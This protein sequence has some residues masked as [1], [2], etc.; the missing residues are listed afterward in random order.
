MLQ[1]LSSS[2]N[3]VLR[4]KF[5]KQ[6]EDLRSKVMTSADPKKIKAGLVSGYML[7]ELV[8]SWVT[9][10][11]DGK[12]PSI[13]DTWTNVCQAELR[14]QVA[15]LQTKY[16]T[17][18]AQIVDSL[19]LAEN[20]LLSWYRGVLEDARKV[21]QAHTS[22]LQESLRA[23]A[24]DDLEQ[25]F[26]D[27]FSALQHLNKTRA[28][29]KLVE[30]LDKYVAPVEQVVERR[31]YECWGGERGF[32]EAKERAKRGVLAAHGSN[33][34]CAASAPAVLI[35][36]LEKLT[37]KAAQGMLQHLQVTHPIQQLELSLQHLQFF[38][39][40]AFTPVSIQNLLPRMPFLC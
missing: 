2:S 15:A 12:V 27:N 21:F 4:P 39:L 6:M 18:E 26:A 36:R 24:L 20:E 35:D 1:T 29:E 34:N 17:Q 33:F 16:H 7:V 22:T 32:Q 11:N 8:Q 19:P 10:V 28:N 40:S 37:S 38:I 14:K 5:V 3:T 31:G 25:K 30:L 23:S 9:A 13:E